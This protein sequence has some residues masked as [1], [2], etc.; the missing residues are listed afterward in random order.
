MRYITTFIICVR[1]APGTA[2]QVD[3]DMEEECGNQIIETVHSSS[4]RSRIR[5]E[6]KSQDPSDG[7]EMK[8]EGSRG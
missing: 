4:A 5:N 2:H 8:Y 6:G 1:H 7:L 3:N